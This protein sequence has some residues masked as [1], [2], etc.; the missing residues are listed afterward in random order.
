MDEFSLVNKEQRCNEIQVFTSELFGNIRI[1]ME[2]GKPLFCGS[3][4]AKALGYINAP[5]ALTRHC[6]YIVKHDTP[7]AQGNVSSMR[8]LATRRTSKTCLKAA[9]LYT[10][11]AGRTMDGLSF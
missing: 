8:A 7:T 2:D 9:G 10:T 1:I 4:V 3:D 5:D 6:R 11:A